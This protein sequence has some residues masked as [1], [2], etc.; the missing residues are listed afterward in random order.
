MNRRI[1][2]LSDIAYKTHLQNN[3]DSSFGRRQDYDNNF[4]ELIVAKC[5]NQIVEAMP[6]ETNTFAEDFYSGYIAGMCCAME[7][8]KNELSN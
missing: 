1:K 3:P 7:I 2:E 5:I 6:P 4:A 8:I